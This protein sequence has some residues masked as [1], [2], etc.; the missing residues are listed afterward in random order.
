MFNIRD[1]ITPR[2]PTFDEAYANYEFDAARFL[3]QHRPRTIAVHWSE[4]KSKSTWVS[5]E[6]YP[7]N[8]KTSAS[9]RIKNHS[10]F[11]GDLNLSLY[12]KWSILNYSVT[13]QFNLATFCFCPFFRQNKRRLTRT[14]CFETYFQQITKWKW[15]MVKLT[16]HSVLFL[17]SSF[18]HPARFLMVPR[19]T[20]ISSHWVP[21]QS[22]AL[23]HREILKWQPNR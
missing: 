15:F 5:D 17:T 4:A 10:L 18:S 13:F 21:A 3:S 11:F 14:Q 20:T 2:R 9:C 7:R 6:F 8:F 16:G 12:F 19:C 23:L 1:A 22:K